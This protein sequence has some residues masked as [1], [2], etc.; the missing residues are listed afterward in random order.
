MHDIIIFVWIK[1]KPFHDS[2]SFFSKNGPVLRNNNAL[3]LRD[4]MASKDIR[5]H[6][7]HY[8][9]ESIDLNELMNLNQCLLTTLLLLIAHSL[10]WISA[11]E[12]SNPLNANKKDKYLKEK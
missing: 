11:K 3:N 7:L 8:V 10:Q 2:F 4:S 1:R 6:S 5:S 12:Y 9:G